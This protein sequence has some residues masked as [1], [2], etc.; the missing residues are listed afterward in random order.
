MGN[1][2]N[3]SSSTGAQL[4]LKSITQK[5][6]S[7]ETKKIIIMSGAGISTSAGVP[8]FRSPNLGIYFK[9]QKYKLP[10]PEAIFESSYFNKNPEPFYALIRE[11]Y[12][13]KLVPTTTHKFF[14]LLENKNLLTR[15]YTQNIDALEHLVHIDSQKIIEA[16]GT[17][18][19][20]TCLKCGHTNNLK[21][22][23]EQLDKQTGAVKC[24]KD[25]CNGVIKPD[26]VLF[27]D[28]LPLRYF[29]NIKPDF[30]DCDLLI[31]LGTSLT[32][33][34]FA[35]LITEGPSKMDRLFINLTKP[36]K[37]GGLAGLF[38]G[39]DVTFNRENDCIE[40][41]YCDKVVEKICLDLGWQEELKNIE[42]DVLG[43]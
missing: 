6:K 41:D 37:V 36:G 28:S 27:G 39:G 2:L 17:F 1:T 16:H 26:L 15:I 10:Y 8:D 43:E 23:K 22:F 19:T 25:S 35:S 9:L 11:L 38:M 20:N 33:Q 13:K 42:F 3:T 18:Q 31:I 40:M 12:P 34:P 24:L 32:V 21:W 5:I 4:S 7:C 30:K 14:K 29:N